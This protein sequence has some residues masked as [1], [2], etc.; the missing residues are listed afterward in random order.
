M[1][2][3]S[4]AWSRMLIVCAGVWV[5]LAA[6]RCGA[7]ASNEGSA[8]PSDLVWQLGVRDGSRD[9]F[10]NTGRFDRARGM[11]VAI[12]CDESSADRLTFT[13]K[14]D[15]LGV[16]PKPR[17]PLGLRNATTMLLQ[18]SNGAQRAIVE[19]ED[20]AG[21]PEELEIVFTHFGGDGRDLRVTLPGER[22]RYLD[23]SM[24]PDV[25]TD[26]AL[27][28]RLAFVAHKGAN[29]IEM[30]VLSQ[31]SPGYDFD[32]LR[33]R[34]IEKA[35][36]AGVVAP[37]V[38]LECVGDQLA[39]IYKVGQSPEARVRAVNLQADADAKINW[40]AK[41]FFGEV[42]DEG[43]VSGRSSAD[44]VLEGT[45]KPSIRGVGF[46]TIGASVG[47]TGEGGGGQA[48]ALLPIAVFADYAE[49][50]AAR[51]AHI[52]TDLLHT[53]PMPDNA[54][55]GR[56]VRLGRII[57]SRWERFG[58]LMWG[59]VEPE[60]GRF[61]W[62][63]TDR[64]LDEW[65]KQGIDVTG[66]MW[67]GVHANV[68]PP[69]W[70]MDPGGPGDRGYRW[71]P[72]L[73]AWKEFMEA[74]VTHYG[75]RIHT[76]EILN[77]PYA[78]LL[79]DG[80]AYGRMLKAASEVIRARQPDARIVCGCLMGRTGA[81]QRKFEEDWFRV[82]GPEALD[83]VGVH[84][85]SRGRW[86][87]YVDTM[88]AWGI[89][90]PVW[91]TECAVSVGPDPY[92]L[93]EELVR[94]YVTKLALGV[95]RMSL[96]EWLRQMAWPGEAFAVSPMMAAH[97]TLAHQL[98]Y[99]R[100]IGPLALERD[101]ECH[102]FELSGGDTVLV[103]WNAAC[104]GS[105]E[106][107]PDGNVVAGRPL[108]IPP[109]VRD[110]TLPAG[111]SKATLIDIMDNET[112]LGRVEG[113]VHVPV[114]ASPLFVRGIPFEVIERM[115]T[116]FPDALH[117]VGVRGDVIMSSAT[118]RNVGSEPLGGELSVMLPSSWALTEKPGRLD[119]SPG[120]TAPVKFAF[121]I[122]ADASVGEYD[123]ALQLGRKGGP[124]EAASRV[125]VL[126]TGAP[127][128][129]NLV[130]G[131]LAAKPA[132]EFVSPAVDVFPGEKYFLGAEVR[133]DSPVD[134]A[135]CFSAAD[136]RPLSPVV[137][138]QFD[139]KGGQG[140]LGGMTVAPPGAAKLA[141][142]ARSSVPMTITR[143]RIQLLPDTDVRPTRLRNW[144]SCSVVMNDANEI[145]IDRMDQTRGH[146]QSG[147]A[148]D[149]PFGWQGPEDLS[150]TVRLS[151]DAN[152]LHLAATV[153]DN[154]VVVGENTPPWA[155]WYNPF[156]DCLQVV[157][158]PRDVQG[159][160]YYYVFTFVGDRVWRTVFEPGGAL[161]RATIPDGWVSAAG[162]PTLV[163]GEEVTGR[164]PYQFEH[165]D[166]GLG[167]AA[168][169]PWSLMDGIHPKPGE[170]IGF[171]VRVK[172]GDMEGA[173]ARRRG[174]MEWSP[175]Y[176]YYLLDPDSFGTLE[177][178]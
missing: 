25:E 142:R 100:Y 130:P 32:V 106:R 163:W 143:P 80:E 156:C 99:A 86:Q 41:N 7:Q 112:A 29:R 45:V 141:F 66:L 64:N 8:V 166:T 6:A 51:D 137:V 79:H 134:L 148:V 117:V 59:R 126:V 165:T 152:A 27:H 167:Y 97:R 26:G 36:A 102:A 115:V 10:V 110:V 121:R 35:P 54:F 30:E 138:D 104:A 53:Q 56:C 82:A 71:I 123:V 120:E 12:P 153:R 68:P 2:S 131:N 3:R 128:L 62:E 60:E 1:S 146:H 67:V 98:N 39:H 122:P 135:A 133:S 125:Q 155:F 78:N 119:V 43:A 91:D 96:H 169:L 21:G 154:S 65:V 173:N 44:G 158:D 168:T 159:S 13:T 176:G 101:V 95:Q 73:D 4:A 85:V 116:I 70:A 93:A 114:G 145:R 87:E 140:I 92:S 172:D 113:V 15:R 61:D 157:L 147:A 107:A 19:W 11:W 171:N 111:V 69:Q 46:F 55:L 58:G 109:F 149:A 129:S 105:Q 77:E 18:G 162:T 136:G 49:E 139:G 38:V 5:W 37:F 94:Y 20:G 161:R 14:L 132:P 75:D 88:K 24:F 16:F 124:R 76:W 33:V 72:R 40:V 127:P 57:G 174:Y 50:G 28:W 144:A 52:G 89:H 48:R 164:I 17:F 150:A 178:R 47:G 74:L 90:K 177:F 42:V 108:S 22:M 84:Y 81:E 151:Y 23:A 160:T 170:A 9:E 175:G 34:R 63:A 103:M 118:V 31:Q 83:I